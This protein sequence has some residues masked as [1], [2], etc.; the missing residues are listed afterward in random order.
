M[1]VRPVA[2]VSERPHGQLTCVVQYD[3]ESQ[4]LGTNTPLRWTFNPLGELFVV[5]HYNGVDELALSVRY[6]R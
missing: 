4:E 3:D 5:Y 2:N 1:P 6:C